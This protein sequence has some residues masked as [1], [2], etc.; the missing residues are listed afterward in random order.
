MSEA[1]ERLKT[2]RK[3][4]G[5]TQAELADESGVGVTVIRH[6]EQGVR[7]TARM[8][9]W[10][11]LAHTLQIPTMRL[12]EGTDD[13][14]V[15]EGT[16]ETWTAVREVLNS[17]PGTLA[18]ESDEPPTL[19]GVRA[20]VGESLPYFKGQF[21]ALAR[22]LP[23]ILRDVNALGDEGQ[24]LR[25]RV[26]QL[27]GWALTMTRQFDLAEDALDRSMDLATDRIQAAETINNLTWLYL[28]RGELDRARNTAVKWAD[29]TEPT[30]LRRATPDE[31]SA[32]GW[33]LLRVSAACIRDNRPGEASAA[34]KWARVA[35]DAL[36]A[37]YQPSP[38]VTLRT[39]GPTTVMLKTAENAAVT[40]HPEEVLRLARRVPKG[41]VRP[42][43]NNLNRH[44]LDVADAQAKTGDYT[45][46]VA[47]LLKIRRRYPEWLAHQR[48]AGDVVS[49]IAEKRRLIT[50]ELRE[51][52]SVVRVNL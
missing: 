30:K 29:E 40:G 42:T 13:P 21:G 7:A 51:V 20:V 1:G 47:R 45:G 14:G 49:R 39:F 15:T 50:P 9:T 25:A 18:I 4:R 17:P 24:A 10:R 6:L 46:S 36:G 32:W 5:L 22:V 16:V 43:T 38:F 11:K 48:Y 19:D 2:A 8:E 35:G 28:R 26:L 37:E 31:L 3:W 34:M 23:G 52:A 33:M 41:G 12:A 27:S 44:Q